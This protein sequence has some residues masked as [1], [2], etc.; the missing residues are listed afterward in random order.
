MIK[1]RY[2]IVKYDITIAC[3][4]DCIDADWELISTH[5][6]NRSSRVVFEHSDDLL[7]E[8]ILVDDSNVNNV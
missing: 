3:S 2:N 8:V 6:R 7:F 5:S 4:V 1:W